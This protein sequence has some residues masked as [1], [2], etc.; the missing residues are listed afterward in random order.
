MTAPNT[1]LRAARMGRLMSQDDL[2]RALRDIGCSS[3]NKRLVQRWESGTT[4]TPRPSHASALER[5]LGLPIEHLGFAMAHVTDD[6]HGGHDVEPAEPTK[7]QR[8]ATAPRPRANP[9]NYSGIWLSHYEYYSSGRKQTFST[10]HYV[11]ILQH[12]DHLTV[13]SLPGS[14]PSV[15]S[16]ELDIDGG[17]ATGTWTED[18]DP[19]GY[20]RGARYNGAIQLLIEPTGHR[21]V[22]KWIGYGKNFDINSGPWEFVLQD[23]STSKATIEKYDHPPDFDRV[24][25]FKPDSE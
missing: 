25:P 10:G 3:A 5:V 8:P 12:G 9:G 23:P 19:H 15:M 11:V 17:V 4:R 7:L 1:A 21:L 20:Y 13:R 6:G 18:T 2:A 14:A 22:G 24:P 16:M